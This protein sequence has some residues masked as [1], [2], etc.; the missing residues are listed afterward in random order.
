MIVA[1]GEAL[2]DMTPVR[3]GG[4][5]A[6]LPRPGGSSNNLAVALG[7]LGASVAFLGRVSSDPFGRLLLDNL[8]ENGVDTRYVVI[9]PEPTTLAIVE[10]AEG[11][12]PAFA[13]YAEGA[14][15][16]CLTPADLPDAFDESVEALHFGSISLL[17]EPAASTLEALM[18][19]ES[20]RRVVTLDPN[21]RPSLIPDRAA[22][23]A[24]FEGWVRLADIVK[25]SAA[26]LS[27]LYPDMPPHDAAARL[28]S[29]GPSWVVLTLGERGAAAFGTPGR[30]DV[31]GEHVEVVDTVGAGDAFGAGLLAW[32]QRH[33]RLCGN[34]IADLSDADMTSA[35]TLAVRVAA[36]TCTRAGADPPQIEELDPAWLPRH[37]N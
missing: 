25:V 23:V 24:S 11:H 1:C 3:V 4:R 37:D 12:D 34:G 33:G 18:R 28:Q 7:R 9:G 14:A 26:D 32:L 10:L 31:P 20:P 19:R 35:I 8:V 2:I 17:A 15:D 21:V 29:L 30:L 6:Y 27:W 13:F 36:L 16:R 22:Y 5:W